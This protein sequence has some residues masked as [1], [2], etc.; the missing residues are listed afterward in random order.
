MYHSIT[1]G[2]KNTWDDWF[3]IPTSRP[4]FNPPKPKTAYIDIP[5]A[6]GHLDVS[7]S[8]TG[9]VVYDPRQ[10]SIEFVVDNW[11]R[12]W[13]ELYSDILHYLHGK[14]MRAVLE[15]D[16][17][18]YYE[19]R[20]TVNQWKS[21][22]HNSKITIDYIVHPYK[23]E[24]F[25]SLD[26][27]LWDSFNFET[28][29][30][31]EYKDLRV[32]ENLSLTVVGSRKSVVPSF[33]VKSDNGRGLTVEFNGVKYALPDGVSKVAGIVIGE[34]ESTLKFTGRGTVSVDYRGGRL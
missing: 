29:V 17:Q 23:F 15:D 27:W 1:F 7:E 19:G 10:G 11:H 6:D 4:V 18:Y 30:I 12:E 8:L 32:S 22:P 31:R 14:T 26:D 25:S 9:A 5:G 13:H 28:G 2:D 16:P 24:L 33:I 3:L 20:F 21:D 34:G